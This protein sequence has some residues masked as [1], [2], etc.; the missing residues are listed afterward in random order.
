MHHLGTQP[1]SV[2]KTE[3]PAQ[4]QVG[5][6]GYGALARH[7]V[8]DALRR[9]ADLLASRYWLMPIGFRNSSSRNSPGVTGLSLRIIVPRQ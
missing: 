2:G 6:G 4:A 8:T 9:C 7:D 3:E 5:V 1:V